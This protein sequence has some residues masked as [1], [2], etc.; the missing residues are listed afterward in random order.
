MLVGFDSGSLN[1][2]NFNYEFRNLDRDN[3]KKLYRIKV[4][5]VLN[6]IQS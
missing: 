1:V 4:R 2:M 5:F 3:F 6:N